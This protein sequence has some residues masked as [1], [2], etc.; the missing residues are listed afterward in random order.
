[1]KMCHYTLI[2]FVGRTRLEYVEFPEGNVET[3][4]LSRFA[5]PRLP[6]EWSRAPRT[7]SYINK[8]V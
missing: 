5:P 7:A 4:L 3:N 8:Q 2:Y 6:W 1:M